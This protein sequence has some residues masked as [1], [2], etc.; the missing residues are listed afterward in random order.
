[1]KIVENGL[2]AKIFVK[3]KTKGEKCRNCSFLRQIQATLDQIIGWM[4][5]EPKRPENWSL[6][7]IQS[8]IHP[9]ILDQILLGL[10]CKLQDPGRISFI[11]LLL[12]QM[13]NTHTHTHT[14]TL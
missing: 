7:N 12:L 10:P 4:C 2:F 13:S 8:G 14:L 5:R 6:A 3:S 1:M 11:I 9:S